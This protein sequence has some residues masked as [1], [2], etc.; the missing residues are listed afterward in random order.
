M[1][2]WVRASTTSI[3]R[4]SSAVRASSDSLRASGTVTVIADPT[5]SRK[6]RVSRP[7]TP[8]APSQGDSSPRGGRRREL[9]G[10]SWNGKKKNKKKQ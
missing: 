4:P 2:L 5:P 3:A 6:L 8:D 9:A 7:D 1:R 10:E